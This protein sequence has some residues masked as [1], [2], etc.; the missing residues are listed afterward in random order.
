MIPAKYWGSQLDIRAWLEALAIPCIAL[1]L[2]LFVSPHDPFLL[3]RSFP[4]LWLAPVLIALRYGL[5]PA[6]LSV[7]VLLGSFVGAHIM[8]ASIHSQHLPNGEFLG[9]I[10]LTLLAG[11]YGSS[12]ILRLRRSE[13]ISAYASQQLEALTRTL[14]LTRLS[15]DRLEQSVISKPVTL[16]DSLLDLR[17]ALAAHGGI[18][19]GAVAT[20]LLHLT[21]YHGGFEQA[22]LYSVSGGV[23]DP[24]ARAAVG[25]PITLSVDDIL[26]QRCLETQRV[27]YWAANSLKDHEQSAYLV[28]APMHT[29]DGTLLGLLVVV[30]M[31]FL[32]LTEDN[33]LAVSVLLAYFADDVHALRAAQNVLPLLPDCP[34]RFAADL[35][36]LQRVARDLGLPSAVVVVLCSP[37]PLRAKIFADLSTLPRELDETWETSVQEE[38]ALVTLMPFSSHAVAEGYRHR[39]ERMLKDRYNVEVDGRSVSIHIRIL[40]EGDMGMMLHQLL[41]AHYVS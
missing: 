5:G 25:P 31:P 23:I 27:A 28:A 9:G 7:A 13:Q 3:H 12:W 15:H 8:F 22:A 24:V 2:G 38:Q 10:I 39:I 20:R 21:A 16:R 18:L 19:E 32:F 34:L 41:T 40:G 35:F 14:H 17:Q 11:E 4:W 26:I 37:H 6:V 36:K 29:S 1:G 30:T 33:L